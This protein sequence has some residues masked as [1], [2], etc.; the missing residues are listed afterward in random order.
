MARRTSGT[1][2]MTPEERALLIAQANALKAGTGQAARDAALKGELAGNQIR[3]D[4]LINAGK[5]DLGRAEI[6]QKERQ[7]NLAAALE[8]LSVGSKEGVARRGEEGQNLSELIQHGNLDQKTL[9]GVL[10]ASGQP[11][12][13]NT[14]AQG[15]V[16]KREAAVNALVPELQKPNSGGETARSKKFRGALEALAGPGAYDEALA[17]AYPKP[18]NAAARAVPTPALYQGGQAAPSGGG[19]DW[20]GLASKLIGGGSTGSATSAPPARPAYPELP[21]TP[22]TRY[23]DQGR[24]SLE[25]SQLTNLEGGRSSLTTPSGGTI[26]FNTPQTERR[27]NLL[28]SLINPSNPSSVS[29]PPIQAPAGINDLVAP[30][31]VTPTAPVVAQNPVPAQA[32]TPN[33]TAP[34]LGQLIAPTGAPTP[35]P[36]PVIAPTATPV[37]QATP[38]LTPDALALLLKQ[39]QQY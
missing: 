24:G 1:E 22:E 23:V 3:S 38:Q 31:N 21:N 8:A 19:T 7:G 29:V 27:A 26:G 20:A 15:D 34:N 33:V 2:D 13:Y 16:A 12:L 35:I 25:G 11:G 14:L 17:R 9:A 32:P 28:G 37:P 4:E 18:E 10:A 30:A 36:V 5:L 6:G 39:K